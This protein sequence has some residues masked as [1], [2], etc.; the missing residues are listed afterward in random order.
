MST[1][2]G[3]GIRDKSEAAEIRFEQQSI[4]IPLYQH[5]ALLVILIMIGGLVS[6]L[7]Y[8]NTVKLTPAIQALNQVHLLQKTD[9]LI[10]H[11]LQFDETENFV[12][13]HNKF[14]VLNRDLLQKSSINKSIFQQW[15]NDNKLAT[16]IVSRIQDSR[17]RNQ[18]LKQ[19]SIIQLQLMLFSIQPIINEQLIKHQL[20][21]VNQ[22]N[23]EINSRVN[24]YKQSIQKTNDLQQLKNLLGSVLTSFESL[25]LKTTIRSVEQ[26]RIQLEELFT[27]YKHV[28]AGVAPQKLFD[29]DKHFNEL[30][31]IVLTEQGALIKWQNYIRLVQDY[32]RDLKAQQQQIKLLLLEPY[33]YVENYTASVLNAFLNKYDIKISAKDIVATLIIAIGLLLLC[34]LYLLWTIRKQINSLVQ[35]CF[36]KNDSGINIQEKSKVE[37]YAEIQERE[38]QLQSERIE[39]IDGTLRKNTSIEPSQ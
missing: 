34:F 14:I 12:E 16:D 25:N 18:Q 4:L 7:F 5:I 2:D 23:N 20:L 37:N 9:E 27:L 35:Q 8:Q 11:L 39:A 32:Q 24:L 26:L 10:T 19:S 30:E 3:V 22:L 13:L 38:N 28:V 15:L 17:T 21:E 1:I 31:K 6:L 36:K 29:I 33:R